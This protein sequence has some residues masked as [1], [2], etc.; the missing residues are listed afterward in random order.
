MFVLVYGWFV[1]YLAKLNYKS[2]KVLETD[3]AKLHIKETYRESL[4]RKKTGS[5]MK[6]LTE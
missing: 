1:S 4:T 6:A 5:K 2:A 3:K